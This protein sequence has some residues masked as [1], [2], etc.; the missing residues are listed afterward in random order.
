MGRK[1]ENWEENGK[2][3]GSLPLRTGRAGYGPDD[4]SPGS[5]NLGQFLSRLSLYLQSSKGIYPS[6]TDSSPA[7]PSVFPYTSFNCASTN[8][9]ISKQKKPKARRMIASRERLP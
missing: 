8:K 7:I 9:D 4:G 2:V 6:P 1:R 5:L 3:A